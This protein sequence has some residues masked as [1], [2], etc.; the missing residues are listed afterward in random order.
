MSN[1]N[2]NITKVTVDPTSQEITNLE[3]NGKA[4]ESG[5]VANLETIVYDA[6]NELDVHDIFPSGQ[7]KPGEVMIT[8][9]FDLGYDGIEKVTIKAGGLTG[10]P[11]EGLGFVNNPTTFIP[12]TPEGIS[13]EIPEGEAWTGIITINPEEQ[14]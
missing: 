14:P 3:I 9:D 8:P 12:D 4:F 6:D 10:Y 5:G 7:T 13:I 11:G 2:F 1:S